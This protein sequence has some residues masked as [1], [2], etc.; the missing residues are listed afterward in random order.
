MSSPAS[1]A[2]GT[3]RGYII[4][5]RNQLTTQPPIPAGWEISTGQG[6]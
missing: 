5:L 1:T 6:Q 2:W 4:L 3:I